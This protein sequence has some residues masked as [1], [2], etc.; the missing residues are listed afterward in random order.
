MTFNSFVNISKSW[1]GLLFLFLS[2][3]PSNLPK[4]PLYIWLPNFSAYLNS[5]KTSPSYWNHVLTQLWVLNL[6]FFFIDIP[7]WFFKTPKHLHLNFGVNISFIVDIISVAT[8]LEGLF[9]V[10]N[11]GMYSVV[12]E[13][14]RL[15]F[16]ST[17][18]Q[19]LN[20]SLF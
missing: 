5:F 10:G 9:W 17:L 15:Y 19:M 12:F 16:I 14:T 3:Y 20:I 6:D 4:T 1:R 2:V 7:N 8:K 11:V 13:C 18:V